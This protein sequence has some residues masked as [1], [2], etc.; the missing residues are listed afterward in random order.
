MKILF[1]TDFSEAANHAFIYALSIADKLKAE[2]LTIH[3]YKRPDIR[4]LHLPRT[5]NEVYNDMELQ[6]FEEYRASISDLQKLIDERGQTHIPVKHILAEGEI[7]RQILRAA[8]KESIDF[9]VIGTKGAGWLKQIF[10]GTVAAEVM[11]NACCPVLAVPEKAVFDGTI[12]KIGV[13]TSFEIEEAEVM[14][15][16]LKFAR[17]FNADLYCLHVNVLKTDLDITY[18]NAFKALFDGVGNLKFVVLEGVNIHK[19]LSEYVESNGFDMLA[20]LSHRRNFLEEI[21]MYSEAKMMAYRSK[22]PILAFQA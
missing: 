1:P 3:V 13:T 4:A 14:K 20:M 6:E 2:I 7:M 18:E 15:K 17:I 19:T 8:K 5:L 10:I 22:T 12:N 11:E 16:A 9:I 21:M